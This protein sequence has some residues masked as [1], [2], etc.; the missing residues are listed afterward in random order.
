MMPLKYQAPRQTTP[1]QN[2]FNR[3]TITQILEQARGNWPNILESL[4][5][6]STYL[7]N[8]H[9]PCPR[10]GGKDRFRFDDRNGLGTFY[11]NHCGAGYGIK[12]LQLYHGWSPEEAY[13]IVAR[14]LGIQ[15]YVS[16][17]RHIRDILKELPLIKHSSQQEGNNDTKQSQLNAVWKQS[18]PISSGD[19]VDRYLRS[20]YIELNDFPRV[21][22]FHPELPYYDDYGVFLGK[23]PAMLALLQNDKN[24]KIT[25]HRTYLGNGCKAD[26]PKPKKLMSPSIPGASLGSAIKL[27]SP[28]DGKIVIAE[29]IETALCFYMATHLPVWAAVS[30]N[31]MERV[32]LPENVVEVVIAADNDKSGRGQIAANELKK[33]LLSEGR[34]V[35]CVMPPR[36]GCDFADILAEAKQ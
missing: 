10:C 9:G 5:I 8:K 36:V 16:E 27:Y 6:S 33:R 12:L 20:R 25:I 23:F 21:L 29:G 34:R 18:Q 14:L 28:V 3:D 30:A 35:K 26:I 24:K 15:W 7:K 4:G 19:F 11:C 2:N 13:N 31:G 17:P 22:R 32:I 1:Y